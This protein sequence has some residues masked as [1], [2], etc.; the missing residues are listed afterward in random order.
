M[1][2]E[3]WPWGMDRGQARK[4]LE[5]STTSDRLPSR[6][7]SQAHKQVQQKEQTQ[8]QAKDQTEHKRKKQH[9]QG[10]KSNGHQWSLQAQ[11][12]GD[13]S[14][15]E[16]QPRGHVYKC[17]SN[18]ES[19]NPEPEFKLVGRCELTEETLVSFTSSTFSPRPPF[20]SLPPP[21]PA[22]C[23]Q[24]EL[25]NRG[26]LSLGAV[27]QLRVTLP[28]GGVA[29]AQ[30]FKALVVWGQPARCCPAEEVERIKRVHKASERCLQRTMFFASSVSQTKPSQQATTSPKYV[31]IKQSLKDCISVR[32]PLRCR[33]K[34][35]Q[36]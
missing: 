21:Q 13:K 5:I 12:W 11:E 20:P 25:W 23:R 7:F 1:D 27:T 33:K 29:S 14:Q 35:Q 2:V 36:L 30:G 32:S 18:T 26:L 10:S 19:G 3:L 9:E 24:E 16:P 6:N 17:Q 15:A 34:D 8:M 31:F 22:G 28:F 4:R